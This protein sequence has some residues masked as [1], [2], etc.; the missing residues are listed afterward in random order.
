MSS[1]KLAA[2]RTH[3]YRLATIFL[4]GKT[5]SPPSTRPPKTK[6]SA[7]ISETDPAGLG[8]GLRCGQGR[9]ARY[10]FIPAPGPFVSRMVKVPLVVWA[11][12]KVLQAVPSEEDCTS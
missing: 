8:T 9:T 11:V 5:G 12:V 2:L 1:P 4:H 6:R 7:R 10:T 3:D